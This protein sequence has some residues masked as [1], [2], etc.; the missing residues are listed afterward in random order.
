[1]I[2]V[3]KN[4]EFSKKTKLVTLLSVL[5]CKG[6]REKGDGVKRLSNRKNLR[7]VL[8]C[9]AVTILMQPVI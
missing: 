6:Y 4:V 2:G 7:I 5:T 1:M 9:I 3:L 8:N